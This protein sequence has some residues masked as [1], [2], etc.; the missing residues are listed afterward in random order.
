MRSL[1]RR[2]TRPPPNEPRGG[3]G[4]PAGPREGRRASPGARGAEERG[5]GANPRAGV[6]LVRAVDAAVTR[7]N[8]DDAAVVGDVARLAPQRPLP[9]VLD[10]DGESLSRTL[11]HAAHPAHLDRLHLRVHRANPARHHLASHVVQ[12]H[13]AHVRSIRVGG[14]HHQH[15]GV[16]LDAG[17]HA[18]GAVLEHGEVVHGV[19]AEGFDA[20]RHLRRIREVVRKHDKLLLGHVAEHGGHLSL[21][22]DDEARL[23]LVAALDAAHVRADAKRLDQHVRVQIERLVERLVLRHH[24]HAAVGVDAKHLTGQILQIALDDHHLIAR[25]EV[26][27]ALRLGAAEAGRQLL[28]VSVGVGAAALAL[29][30]SLRRLLAGGVTLQLVQR[31]SLRQFAARHGDGLDVVPILELVDAAEHV[32]DVAKSAILSLRSNERLCLRASASVKSRAG[33]RMDESL[34]ARPAAVP[35]SLARRCA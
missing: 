26:L 10:G 23:A 25:A 4:A 24:L 15:G 5:A 11:H 7:A 9:D 20:A 6:A 27:I 16:L 12:S 1:S 29:P 34:F 33:G 14:L 18:D 19:L 28:E 2:P 32:D 21:N 22:L 17:H 13:R 8:D 3:A 31:R 30:G 35:S